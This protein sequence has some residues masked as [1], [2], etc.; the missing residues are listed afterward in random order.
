M[1]DPAVIPLQTQ[2]QIL[3]ATEAAKL[4]RVSV[5]T[6]RVLAPD[7]GRKVG[8]YWRFSRDRLIQHV[9]GTTAGEINTASGKTLPASGGAASL[10]QANA[11]AAPAIPRSAARPK[12]YARPS[13]PRRGAKRV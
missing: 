1:T 11:F 6:M 5:R 8:K 12:N 3:D 13:R 7:L 2:G 4:L 9:R 10:S